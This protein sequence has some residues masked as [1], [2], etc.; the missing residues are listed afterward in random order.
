MNRSLN[1]NNNHNRKIPWII[2]QRSSS[3]VHSHVFSSQNRKYLKRTSS[4]FRQEGEQMYID[5]RTKSRSS[6]TSTNSEIKRVKRTTT[7]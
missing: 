5:S 6:I 3:S 7:I 1:S 2:Q 4:V